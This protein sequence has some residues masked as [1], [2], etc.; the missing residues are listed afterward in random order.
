MQRPRTIT[1][2][3]ISFRSTWLWTTGHH[4]LWC[5]P[6]TTLSSAF[7]SVWWRYF[8]QPRRV[9]HWDPTGALHQPTTPP[10]CNWV[11]GEDLLL[12]VGRHGVEPLQGVQL[13]EHQLASYKQGLTRVHLHL[14]LFERLQ[15]AMGHYIALVSFT[16]G[17]TT[18]TLP[19]KDK[20]HVLT[21]N[22]YPRI[23]LKR[24][25]WHTTNETGTTT[26]KWKRPGTTNAYLVY[27]LTTGDRLRL[28]LRHW[29]V[30]YKVLKGALDWR[31]YS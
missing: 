18:A 31:D 2:Q 6:T 25:W 30:D 23:F 10:S 1:C 8:W 26:K 22:I 17:G 14:H 29:D 21:I 11:W 13:P 15:S 7:G 16:M 5:W 4:A 12:A 28:R 20:L 9:I 27:S 24:G 3:G 19:L